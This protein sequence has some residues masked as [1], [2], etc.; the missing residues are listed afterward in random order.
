LLSKLYLVWGAADAGEIALLCVYLI[1]SILNGVYFFPIIH[2]AFFRPSPAAEPVTK[3]REA[4]WACVVPLSIT[5][6]SSVLLFFFPGLLFQ[7]A[8]LMTHTHP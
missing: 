7:L 5:A 2:R 3:F 4:P 6:V 1:S 8:G